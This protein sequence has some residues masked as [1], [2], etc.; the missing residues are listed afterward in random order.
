MKPAPSKVLKRFSQVKSRDRT[1]A[2]SN[3]LIESSGK[4]R[5]CARGAGFGRNA[6]STVAPFALHAPVNEL[7]S[8]EFKAITFSFFQLTRNL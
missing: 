4:S 5:E 2:Y 8:I 1:Q 7:H 3:Y 6:Q